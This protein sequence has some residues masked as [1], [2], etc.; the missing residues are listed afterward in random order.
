MESAVKGPSQHTSSSQAPTPGPPKA[1]QAM[2]SLVSNELVEDSKM[3]P[4]SSFH[5]AEQAPSN[6]CCQDY[7]SRMSSTCLLPLR[8]M[9]QNQQMGLT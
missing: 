8:E 2:A 3:A 6:G 1:S 5:V 9:F 7:V 4:A